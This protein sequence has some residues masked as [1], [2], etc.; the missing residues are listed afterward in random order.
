MNTS[1]KQ[2]L[3][4]Y[5]GLN[6]IDQQALFRFAE[7]LSVT[8]S[9]DERQAVVSLDD[10][11]LTK[12][13]ENETVIGALKRLSSAY[14]MLDKAKMLDKASSLMSD[15]VLRGRDRESV[16]DELEAL[17]DQQYQNLKREHTFND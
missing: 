16:I 11:M 9:A 15:H 4:F 5:R 12:G 3:A 17:F 14:S 13:H 6:A 7:F 1:E 10:V 2:L 8:V